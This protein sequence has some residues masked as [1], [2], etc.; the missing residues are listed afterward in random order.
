MGVGRVGVGWGDTCWNREFHFRHVKS[1]MSSLRCLLEI[2][3]EKSQ[4]QLEIRVYFRNYQLGAAGLFGLTWII[5][6][7][8]LNNIYLF[9][10]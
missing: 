7:Y 1:D 3:V 9:I 8:L 4:K 5:F 10:Y 6:I 2:Q